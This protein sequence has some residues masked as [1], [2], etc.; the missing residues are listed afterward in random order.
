MPIAGVGALGGGAAAGLNRS[1]T[2]EL[3]GSRDSTHRISNAFELDNSILKGV[4]DLP[5]GDDEQHVPEGDDETHATR[6][7]EAE[8]ADREATVAHLKHALRGYDS[9]QSNMLDRRRSSAC[10]D[11]GSVRDTEADSGAVGLTRLPNDGNDEQ[12]A[13]GGSTTAPKTPGPAKSMMTT[14]RRHEVSVRQKIHLTLEDSAYSPLA[15]RIASF[16]M[17]IIFA[18]TLSF[19]LESEVCSMDPCVVGILP[20]HPYAKLFYVFEWIS[21]VIF[22]VEYL[23]RLATCGESMRAAYKFVFELTNLIDL[24]AWLPFFIIGFMDDPVFAAPTL[25]EVSAVCRFARDSGARKTC[26]LQ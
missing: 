8:L 2:G 16:M 9:V 4:V 12:P 6:T 24:V 7:T 19:I 15:G 25:N 20:F 17:V 5:E 14:R 3:R 18:S 26:T 23:I 1:N 13:E 11:E 22:A 10:S 21:V